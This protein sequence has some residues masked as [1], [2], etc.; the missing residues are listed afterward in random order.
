MK[1][2][3]IVGV[4]ALG[5]HVAYALRNEAFLKV[6]DFDKVEQ[7]NVLSQFHGK[8]GVGAN[9]TNSMVQTFA[10]LYGVKLDAV[11]HRLVQ[12]NVAQLLGGSDLVIDCLD[13]ATSRQIV[14]DFCRKQSIPC[15]HGALALGGTFGRS[16]WTE[17]FVIDKEGVGVATCEDGEFLPFIMLV[18]S[19]IAMSAQSFLK[20][21]R[22]VG[23]QIARNSIISV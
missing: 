14:Q 3:T 7:K 15:L 13:N 21:G 23:F 1:K 4:G 10:F 22:K 11:P 16:I 6:I 2:V 17:Q 18:S 9:K 19:A 5:S 8:A 12:N 20:E